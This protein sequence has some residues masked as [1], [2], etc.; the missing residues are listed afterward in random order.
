MVNPLYKYKP[1]SNSLLPPEHPDFSPSAACPP[2]LLFPDAHRRQQAR[3]RRGRSPSP[4]SD[5]DG[6]DADEAQV[7]KISPMGKL[8]FENKGVPEERAPH[9]EIESHRGRQKRART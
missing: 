3:K 2:K 7:D 1:P 6:D 5:V 9:T 4:L 8:T